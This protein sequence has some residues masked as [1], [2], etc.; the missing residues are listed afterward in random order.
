MLVLSLKLTM[1]VF[2]SIQTISEVKDQQKFRLHLTEIK[3]KR[4][5]RDNGKKYV[6]DN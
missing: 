4:V 2:I 5:I 3:C 6:G 1:G